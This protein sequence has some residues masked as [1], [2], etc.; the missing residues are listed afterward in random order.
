MLRIRQ[1]KLP[2]NHTQDE[3]KVKISKK[4]KIKETD[5]QNFQINKQSIDARDKTNLMYVYEIDATIKNE[6][7][8]LKKHQMN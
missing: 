3:L 8:I 4:L 5:I 1:I 2:I 7:Q 6:N